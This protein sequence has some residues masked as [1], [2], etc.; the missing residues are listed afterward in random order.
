MIA[1]NQSENEY[2][3]DGHTLSLGDVVV[4]KNGLFGDDIRVNIYKSDDDVVK[5]EKEISANGRS[6]SEAKKIASTTSI[7][8]SINGNTINIPEVFR[9]AKG[10][11]YRNQN[12][13]YSIYIPKDKEVNIEKGMYWTI[14]K[15]EFKKDKKKK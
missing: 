8:E 1:I 7:A 9:V 13:T 6:R 15:N 14:W 2:L 12:V 4:N 5:I 11:K 10:N 3:E